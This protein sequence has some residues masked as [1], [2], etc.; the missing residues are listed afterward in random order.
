MDNITFFNRITLVIFKKL[1]E[2]FPQPIDLNINAIAMEVIPQD[3]D[4]T[5]TWNS[6]M[7]A[8]QAIDFLAQEGFLTHKG[9]LKDNSKVHQARLT[10]RG[11]TILGSTPD[12]L[13]G[14]TPLI[15]QIKE[16]LSSGANEAKN[17]TFRQLAQ[18]TFNA[19]LAA[20]PRIITNIL[21][22]S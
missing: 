22:N 18:Q 3:A 2:A 6:L 1:Y 4:E 17:E 10:L 19:A 13:D 21:T 12:S 20:A 9:A 5:L 7:A 16:A 11:L 15:D 8:G 14:K